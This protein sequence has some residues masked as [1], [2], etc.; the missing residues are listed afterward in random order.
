MSESG[1]KLTAKVFSV[2]QEARVELIGMTG[3]GNEID[4]QN[5]VLGQMLGDM[6][7]DFKNK[8]MKIASGNLYPRKYEK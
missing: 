1:I 8:F 6:N 7:D 3:K 4:E 2:I 5:I